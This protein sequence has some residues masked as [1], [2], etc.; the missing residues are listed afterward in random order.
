MEG[1]EKSFRSDYGDDQI[2]ENVPTI[3]VHSTVSDDLS[4]LFVVKVRTL[5]YY[6]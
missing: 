1:H 3:L 4:K 5:F 2:E 6:F